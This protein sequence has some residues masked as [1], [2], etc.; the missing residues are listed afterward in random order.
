MLSSVGAAHRGDVGDHHVQRRPIPRRRATGAIVVGLV[1][2]QVVAQDLAVQ[3]VLDR[4]GRASPCRGSRPCRRRSP[5][6]ACRCCGSG[7]ALVDGRVG[8]DRRE[9]GAQRGGA[10]DRHLGVVDGDEAQVARARPDRDVR[11]PPSGSGMLVRMSRPPARS[12]R[13]GSG[14]PRPRRACSV[15]AIVVESAGGSY[16]PDRGRCSG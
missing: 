12:E 13:C 8:E 1:R 2:G 9:V 15:S 11:V 16:S 7:A 14:S 10:G 5:R 4:R 3:G 6:S